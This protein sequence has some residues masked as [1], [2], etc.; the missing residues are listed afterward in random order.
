MNNET[1]KIVFY[2]EKKLNTKEYLI[3]TFK[4]NDS[5]AFIE[6]VNQ[7]VV[8]LKSP[9]MIVVEEYAHKVRGLTEGSHYELESDLLTQLIEEG[10]LTL[11]EEDS[12]IIGFRLNLSGLDN[13]FANHNTG[14]KD[15]ETLISS[16]VGVES[17]VSKKVSSLL[18]SVKKGT[19]E[20]VVVKKVGQGSWNEII[21][22]GKVKL[23]FDIG[24]SYHSKKK[25]VEALA[26]QRIE[27]Y[28]K[29]NPLLVIS[30]WDVDHYHLLA[31]A[32][33][34]MIQAFSGIVGRP[35]LPTNT[36]RR[37]WGRWNKIRKKRIQLPPE[38]LGDNK[39]EVKANRK[40]GFQLLN[41]APF[42]TNGVTFYN[43][44]AQRDRN[45]SGIA[46]SVFS[47]KSCCILPGDAHY[48][49]INN[50]I[51]PH[52]ESFQ[53]HNLV[54]PHHG[55]KAGKYLYNIHFKCR[56]NIAAISVGKNQYGHPLP[57]HVDF[58]RDTFSK[59]ER[60][61]IVGRD[62]EIPLR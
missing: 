18:T 3:D 11:Y 50:G 36:S 5:A 8:D 12:A 10:R 38:Y 56:K 44:F 49:Q 41:G 19:I 53:N 37:V 14:I 16:R 43:G 51:L 33:D 23:V 55:G 30:H 54:A 52:L 35:N 45:K 22:E 31:V 13:I 25:D 59:V 6:I 42:G 47:G 21:A 4:P 46:I 48:D 58:L 40:K 32:P 20:K 61:Q 28:M 1:E 57:R 26:K 29:D 34:K 39:A 60:T 7:E 27:V 15:S 24:A 62:I 2:V 9:T 17:E